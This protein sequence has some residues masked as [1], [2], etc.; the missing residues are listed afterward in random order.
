MI[1]TCLL[2]QDFLSI[3]DENKLS[4][5][6]SLPSLMSSPELQLRTYKRMVLVIFSIFKMA[7]GLLPSG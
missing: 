6:H 1:T 2:F 7:A 5:M 4:D 3:C